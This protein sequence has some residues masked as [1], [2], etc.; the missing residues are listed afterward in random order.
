MSYIKKPKRV[1]QRLGYSILQNGFINFNTVNNP[2]ATPLNYS[3]TFTNT[4]DYPVDLK[5]K[6]LFQAVIFGGSGGNVTLDFKPT[7]FAHI[8]FESL[9]YISSASPGVTFSPTIFNADYTFSLAQNT[10]PVTML[11]NKTVVY[12]TLEWSM[13]LQPGQFATCTVPV[14]MVRFELNGKVVDTVTGLP[15]TRRVNI[16]VGIA[17]EFSYYN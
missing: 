5:F 13:T 4:L 17:K 9:P 8:E 12:S 6:T 1:T 11:G 15:Y 14:K 3:E 10:I 7:D 2:S 16:L